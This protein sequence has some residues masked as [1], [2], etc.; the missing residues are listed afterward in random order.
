MAINFK[1]KKAALVAT[2]ALGAILAFGL[3]GCGA[4][5]TSSDKSAG[6]S[7]DKTIT[8]A[9]TPL[10]MQKSERRREAAPREGRLH[11]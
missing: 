1:K 3:A 8:V 11:P 6:S 4:Q 10:P 7:N 5:G 9:A 2:L